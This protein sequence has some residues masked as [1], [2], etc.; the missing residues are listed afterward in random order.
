MKN[1]IRKSAAEL[2]HEEMVRDIP[3]RQ[4]DAELK[5]ALTKA[6]LWYALHG[7]RFTMPTGKATKGKR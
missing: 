5:D 4:V 3:Q 7:K 2:A 6:K 1:K